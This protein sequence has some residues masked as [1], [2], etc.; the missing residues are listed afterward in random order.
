MND[1][2]L[3]NLPPIRTFWQ[4]IWQGI[5]RWHANR[6]TSFYLLLAM[7][8]VLLLGVQ[9]ARSHND[10]K[11]FFLFL[12]LLFTFFLVVLLRAI[13]DFIEITRKH[14]AEQKRVFR[15]TLGEADFLETLKKKNHSDTD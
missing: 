14:L 9:L 5:R 4:H 13:V 8:V 1:D 15:A 12:A 6:P 7:P 11:K 2:P 3:Y 10:P